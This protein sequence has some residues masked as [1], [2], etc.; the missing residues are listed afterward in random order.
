MHI[1]A[2]HENTSNF[3]QQEA[4]KTTCV[5]IADKVHGQSQNN[6]TSAEEHMQLL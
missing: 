2:R 4:K 5:M 1:Q 3:P 6:S